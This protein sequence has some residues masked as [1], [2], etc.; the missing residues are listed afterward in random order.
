MISTPLGLV[1]A[2]TFLLFAVQVL[3]SLHARSLVSAAAF[4]A[5]RIAATSESIDTEAGAR[6]ADQLIGNMNPRLDWSATNDNEIVLTVVA[7]GPT[8]FP[9]IAP[10]SDLG[11]VSRTARVRRERLR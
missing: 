3:L 4:D 9:D 1:F 2:I 11:E 6:R 5:A 10:L 8:L 7:R